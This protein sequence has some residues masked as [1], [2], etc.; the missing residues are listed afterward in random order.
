[1]LSE[2]EA[3]PEKRTARFLYGGV[4][5]LVYGFFGVL[6]VA[7]PGVVLFRYV[8]ATATNACVSPELVPVSDHAFFVYAHL[9]PLVALMVIAGF[10]LVRSKTRG[11]AAVFAL[12]SA[13]VVLWLL[14]DLV[15][16]IGADPFMR[17]AA[18]A[19]MG[20][21]ELS[22]FALGA[23]FIARLIYARRVPL[24]FSLAL[25]AGLIVPIA[26]VV[27]GESVFLVLARLCNPFAHGVLSFYRVGFEIAIMAFIAYAWSRISRESEIRRPLSAIA[28][29]L[30]LFL[31]V[32]SIASML[33]VLTGNAAFLLYSLLAMPIFI[34]VLVYAITNLELFR[35]EGFGV[36]VL[37]YL[38]LLLVSSLFLLESSTTDRLIIGTTFVLTACFGYLFSRSG[39]REMELRH[40]SERL[41]T[42]LAETN[43]RQEKLIHFVGHEVKGF[44]SH[45]EA[46]FAAIADG[47]FGAIPEELKPFV[48]RALAQTREGVASVSDI[49]KASNL[50]K[51]TT[52]YKKEPFDLEALAAESVEKAR[53]TAEA[54]G[55][56]LSFVSDE[57]DFM[58]VGD[59]GEIGDHVLRN[60]IDNAVNYTPSGSIEVTLKH[61]DGKYVFTV[62]DTGVGISDEDKKRLF[63]EGGHGKESQK[64]N[65]HSTG[66]GLF[67]AKQVTEGHGG[68]IRAES[69]GEGKGSAFTVVLPGVLP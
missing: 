68:T 56:K 15:V 5:A 23:Y 60:L 66:Y 13:A 43:D 30:F 1:M 62:K 2:S 47:D 7:I 11:I 37:V 10:V 24:L 48:E 20:F 55:L 38:I 19:V 69:E 8:F 61:A 33:T 40:R 25:V 32:F 65:A 41:A 58:F 31:G 39:M 64:I 21:L 9:V 49:L 63:T 4:S 22:F 34:I 6:L 44:L 16:G 54:K 36:Q 35:V 51:G 45:D 57:G 42:E 27:S 17:I 59:R 14:G 50:K 28:A 12:F 29:S 52:E 18:Y 46:A 67:I 26:F 3:R 53:P